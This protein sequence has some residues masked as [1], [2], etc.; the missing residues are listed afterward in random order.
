[1]AETNYVT[2]PSGVKYEDHVVGTGE[3]PKQGQ[4]VTVHYTGWLDENGAK[5][6]KFDSSRDRG[7]PFTFKLG[8]GQVISGWD[9]GVATMQAGGQRTL[10]LLPEHG[11]GQRGAGSVIPPGAT[12]IFDVELISFK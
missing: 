2:L 8:V 11:Y 5:G 4:M 3:T 12:L 9:L 7:Q 1:M 10:L 6:R